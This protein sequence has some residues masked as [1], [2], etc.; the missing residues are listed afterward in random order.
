[1]PESVPEMELIGTIGF[2][3]L[4]SNSLQVHPDGKNLIYPLGCTVI[5]EDINSHTQQF[6]TGHTDTIT[7]V[8]VSKNGKYIASGQSTHM[9]YKADI[10]VWDYETKKI[11]SRFVLHK[12]KVEALAF[13]P[14]E[15]YLLSLGGQD[16]GSVVVWNL[17]KK[18]AICGNEAQAKSA[19]TAKCLVYANHSDNLFVTAGDGT[20]R[21]WDL[22]VEKRKI[23]PTDVSMGQVKRNAQCVLMNEDDTYL[24][25]GTSSGDIL[26][27]N[28][29]TRL[30]QHIGPVKGKF[31]LGVTAMAMLITGEVLVGAGDGTV[32]VVQGDKFKRSTKTTTIQGAVKSIA[33]RGKGHQFYVGTSLSHIYCFN[34]TDFTKTLRNT[35][36]SHAVN[37][38]AFAHGA[39]SVFAT[40]SKEDVR[41]WT[42]DKG[43]GAVCATEKLRIKVSNMICNALEF[44]QDGRCIVT[45][46]NDGR[47]RS[48]YPESGKL[49]FTIQDAHNH[50]VTA[51]ACKSDSCTFVSGGGDG[52]VRIWHVQQCPPKNPRDKEK[53]Y[54]ST[55]VAMMKE[56]KAAVTCIKLRSNDKECVSAS[57]DG[58]C[59]I[60]NLE[61]CVRNQIIFAN[62]LFRCVCYNYDECQ[63]VTSGT[64]RKIAYWEVYDGSAIRE[65][66]GSKSGSVNGMDIS[67]CG[68]FF[69]TGGDDKL[70]KIWRYNEGSVTHV[71]LGHSGAITRV[72]ICPSGKKIVSV[73]E[74]G[75]ILVWRCPQYEN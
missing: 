44:T 31:S 70:L 75:A 40:C 58:T 3:G 24:Y 28:T 51:L 12:V 64:D 59:I 49:M 13:S 69:V 74:D 47:I 62:T 36:H 10:I 53:S 60:W 71:G 38:I 41:V 8:A 66:E 21:V 33:V 23:T 46:W 26:G 16:D 48:F 55:L 27:I 52:Q 65:L 14:N 67:P 63:V 43:A 4:V 35:C 17:A 25:C 50:G 2:N 29:K 20:L 6:L 39:S 11:Y 19:G 72:R 54:M 32:S 18:E 37:D 1:M 73:S 42:V 56:H 15:L 30:F 5:I 22:D 34:F 9:G 61:R 7:C 45:A 68:S 57:S